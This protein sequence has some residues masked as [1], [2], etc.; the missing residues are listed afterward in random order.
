MFKPGT[1]VVLDKEKFENLSMTH[2]KK[3]KYYGDLGYGQDHPHFFVFL[4][5]ITVQD[6]LYDIPLSTG[7]CL[8]VSLQ[9]QKVETMRHPDDFRAVTEDEF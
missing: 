1:V 5:E 8:L 2:E 4:C 3:L 9:N 7:H 6:K